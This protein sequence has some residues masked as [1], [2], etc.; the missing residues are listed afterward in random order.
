MDLKEIKVEI[1]LF[2]AIFL[3]DDIPA[4]LQLEVIALRNDPVYSA[5][6]VPGQ[7][8]HKAYIALPA[9]HIYG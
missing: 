5:M 8:L 2:S 7:N 6:F 9:L 1:C 4:R 3:V